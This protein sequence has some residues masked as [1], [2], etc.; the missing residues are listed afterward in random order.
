MVSAAS[1]ATTQYDARQP[2]FWPSQVAAG[3]P[4]TLATGS[5]ISTSAMA[6]PRRSGATMLAATSEATPK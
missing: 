6:R 1:P 4:T 3:T 5:P 2:R